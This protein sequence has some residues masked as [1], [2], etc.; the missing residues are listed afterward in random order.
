[1]SIK[2]MEEKREDVRLV[3]LPAGL[4]DAAEK[5]YGDRFAG[6]EQLLTYILEQLVQDEAEKM[7][8]EEQRVI[9]ERLKDLGYI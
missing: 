1:M 5:K 4:C 7:D 8:R 3:N 2:S 6:V 9:E